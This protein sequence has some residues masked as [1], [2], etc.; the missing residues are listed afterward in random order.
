M[1]ISG[2]QFQSLS[3]ISFCSEKNCIIQD[4]LKMVQQ[5]VHLIDTFPVSDIKNFKRIF[6]YSHDLKKFFNKF[7]NDLADGIT[8]ITHN[9]DYPITEEFLPYLEGNKIKKWFCQNRYINHLKL[10]SLPI[11]VA[12]SQWKHGNQTELEKVMTKGLPKKFLIYKNFDISTNLNKR[13]IVNQITQSNGIPMDVNRPYE[14]YLDLV[15]QSIYVISPPGNGI[16]CHRVWECL[17]LNAVPIVERHTCHNQFEHLPILF[18]NKWEDVNNKYVLDRIDIIRKFT[19]PI[20]ELS[21][22]YWKELICTE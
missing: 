2:E 14:E 16:D 6:V 1:I 3:E 15:A 19:T 10:F 4:Q 5:N 13:S 8:L 20:K 11:G 18:I 9:S 22:D 17:S 7:Y 12:N 21:L